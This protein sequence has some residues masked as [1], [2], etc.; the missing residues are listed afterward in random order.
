MPSLAPLHSAKNAPG[1]ETLPIYGQLI[2]GS[3]ADGASQMAV[4]SPADAKPF[5]LVPDATRDELAQAIAAA[6]S[7]FGEWGLSSFGY[8]RECLLQFVEAIERGADEIATA[9]TREQG[10]PLARA[11][12]EVANAM[13]SI[14]AIATL[15][16]PETILRE[17]DKEQIALRYRPL[18][19]VAGITAWNVPVILAAQK[20]AQAL[21]CGNTM[22]LKPSPFTPVAT[23]LLG[24]ASIGS[25][26]PG[27]LNIVSGG[28]E[29]G[30]WL[31]SDR[32]VSKISFTGSGPTGQ[33]VLK[34]GAPNFARITLELGGNDAAILL[35][36]ADLDIAIPKIFA[37]AFNNAGQICM[38]IKRLYVHADIYE[39]VA[40]RMADMA[41]SLRIG[42][43][44]DP[45]SDMGPVQNISQFEKLRQLLADTKKIAGVRILTGGKIADGPGYFIP[46]TVVADISEGSQLVDQEQFGP[47]LP[48]IRY[49]DV[50]DA[51]SRAN[52]T[53]FGL[54]G[55]IWTSDIVKGS[56]L[57]SRLEVG[58]AWVN[59][60]GGADGHIP[61]GGA[62]ASGI[63]REHGL[64]GLQHYM[65]A[66]VL[67]VI[68]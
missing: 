39:T 61:F 27:V 65:E 5:A 28:N 58:T 23:L 49:E 59:R 13:R 40:G 15:D 56:E 60:H 4:V 21:Y 20:I 25:L 34:S 67:H 50:D 36:D 37:S 43:G 57:A 11:R 30:A 54:S 41:R 47:I 17:N 44:M 18:G 6:R 62:K 24:K 66:Q 26:P 16:L 35:P 38:A 42:D 53:E 46:P 33:A 2:D 1:N 45:E 8:R 22:V 12:M 32:D 7:A 3:L 31:T 48:L 52:A 9:L 14:K 19:V 64:L 63:G 68:K 51:I 10:K 29:L 55:S